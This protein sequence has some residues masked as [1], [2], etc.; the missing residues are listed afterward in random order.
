MNR[1]PDLNANIFR[2]LDCVV[3]GKPISRTVLDIV[4]KLVGFDRG[5][6]FLTG[7]KNDLKPVVTLGIKNDQKAVECLIRRSA[8]TASSPSEYIPDTTKLGWLRNARPLMG[9]FIISYASVAI[10]RGKK[11]Y[12]ILYFDSL[13]T[14]EPIMEPITSCLSRLARVMLQALL[15]DQLISVPTIAANDYLTTHS[16]PDIERE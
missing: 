7:K 5:A 8:V 1:Q 10:V 15:H 4:I 13:T 9:S 14:K 12:G 11:Q 3:E 2:L 16:I 6:V